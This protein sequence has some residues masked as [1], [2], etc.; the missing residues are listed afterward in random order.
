MSSRKFAGRTIALDMLCC[1]SALPVGKKSGLEIDMP[2][3][4]LV[5]YRPIN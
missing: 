2:G 5:S 4:L 3:E 1:H